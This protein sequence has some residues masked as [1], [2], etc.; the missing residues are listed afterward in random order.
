MI[1]IFHSVCLKH[2][3]MY[4]YTFFV[5][6]S[7]KISIKE[8]VSYSF[9]QLCFVFSLKIIRSLTIGGAQVKAVEMARTGTSA[10]AYSAYHSTEGIFASSRGHREELKIAMRVLGSGY[11]S[12]C[13]QIK[14]YK[15][16]DDK[17]CEWGSKLH[18]IELECS[19]N[20]GQLV[21]VNCETYRKLANEPS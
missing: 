2:I 9:S 17:H 19:S 11:L 3:Y 5:F 14:Y 12:T 16:D 7:N 21:T 18:C 13:L 8:F 4:I 15:Q 10:C 20:E 6:N 1:R